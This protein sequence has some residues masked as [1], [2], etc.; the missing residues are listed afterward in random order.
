MK[1]IDEIRGAVA[2]VEAALNSAQPG[3]LMLVQ[4]DTIDETVD[5][6]RQYVDALTPPPAVPVEATAPE[7][8]AAET[9]QS[10]EAE[11][12]RNS[13]LAQAPVVAKVEPIGQ[14]P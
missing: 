2:A 5:Y 3:E 14:C 11:A 10:L 7:P 13:L 6:V 4:A 8:P 12:V 9:A 1:Q